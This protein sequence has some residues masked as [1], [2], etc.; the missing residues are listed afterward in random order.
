M[1]FKEQYHYTVLIHMEP[2]YLQKNIKVFIEETY[3]WSCV[4]V[5]IEYRG[6]YVI[7]SDKVIISGIEED[8]H[9]EIT[10]S[11]SFET[12]VSDICRKMA[13]YLAK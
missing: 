10:A 12:N 6:D 5:N 13:E 11:L 2:N 9:M 1:N 4:S 3:E 8:S 7:G